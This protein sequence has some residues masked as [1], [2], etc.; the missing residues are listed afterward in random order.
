MNHGNNEPVGC[1]GRLG[2]ALL[3]FGLGGVVGILVDFDHILCATANHIPLWPLSNLYGCKIW[4]DHLAVI[5]IGGLG[6]T[7]ALGL[8]LVF[9]LVYHTLEST[10]DNQ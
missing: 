6:L 5:G 9:Y 4:H 7:C 10:T 3:A 8:G 2:Y 1:F